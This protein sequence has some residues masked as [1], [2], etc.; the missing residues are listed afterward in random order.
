VNTQ[1]ILQFSQVCVNDALS[2]C[3]PLED[4]EPKRLHQAMR[5]SV[6]SGGKRLR[7]ALLYATGATLGLEPIQLAQQ[8]DPLA[9]AVE[10]I[11]AYS[12]IHDDLPAMDDDN[13]RR[14]MPTC[15]RAF[16][17]ATAILAGDALQVLAFQLLADTEDAYFSASFSAKQRVQMI[18]LLAKACGS[19]GM[20]GGQAMDLA[21][22]G[23]ANLLTLAELETLYRYKTGY[24]IRASIELAVLACPL[25]HSQYQI[26]AFENLIQYADAIGLAFQIQD[27]ILDIEVST[28]VLGKQQGADRAKQKATYPQLAGLEA[29]KTKVQI[30]YQ[31]A[32]SPLDYF[33]SNADP[34]RQ[35]AGY[36]ICRNY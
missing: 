6:L 29:A 28:D 25:S 17:E 23:Q 3:L 13:L 18:S 12:L 7:P 1:D 4:T 15:H 31:Q 19:V 35:L 36:I 26:D 21:A 11:H 32:L 20:A 8:L 14:G 2:R 5:Y 24:L 30:L 10:L 34:L 22:T 16:D 27:D 9:C 33:G